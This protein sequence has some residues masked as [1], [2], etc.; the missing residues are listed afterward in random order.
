MNSRQIS[1]KSI[2]AIGIGAALFFVLGRFLIIPTP[3][4]NTNI[5]IQYAILAVF[6]VIYGPVVGVFTGFIG[7]TLIDLT[8]GAPWW[9]WI[10]AS[11]VFG[12]IIGCTSSIITKEGEGFGLKQIIRFNI[13]QVIAHAISWLVVAPTLDILVYIEPVKKVFVQGATSTLLNAIGTG[14]VGTIILVSYAKTTTHTGSL[15]K[16]D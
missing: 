3:I 5:S 4:P 15:K 6:G 16:E 14:V 7:H 9:S 10:I 13:I 12:L 8:Y 2:V 1:I 11:A